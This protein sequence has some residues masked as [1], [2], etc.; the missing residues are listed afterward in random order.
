MILFWRH[1]LLF[2]WKCL[3]LCQIIV[4]CGKCWFS[5]FIR[6]CWCYLLWAVETERNHHWGT[7]LNAINAFEPSIA[8]KTAT[9]RAGAQKVILQHE[10]ARPDFA[11]PVKTY[12]ETLKWEVLPHLPYSPDIARRTIITC[13]GRWHIYGLADRQFRSYEDIEKRLDSWIASKDEHFY[14]NGIRAPPER[15]TKVVANDGHYFEWFIYN[16]FFTIKL[17]FHK[18][19]SGNLVAHLI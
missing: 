15:W 10:N 1:I 3:I 13:F 4:I 19:N 12:L 14:R 6:R 5:P 18:K 9:I 2:V 17:H 16:H 11:K 7:V 8:R